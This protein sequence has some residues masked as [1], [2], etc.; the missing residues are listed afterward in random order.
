MCFMYAYYMH[1]RTRVSPGCTLKLPVLLGSSTD[2]DLARNPLASVT[3]T[4]VVTGVLMKDIQVLQR[5]AAAVHCATDSA[6]SQHVCAGTHDIMPPHEENSC[7]GQ[8]D[9]PKK[10][11]LISVV[12][13]LGQPA[14]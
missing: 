10:L 5:L 11:E 3:V 6:R 12:E 9:G 1:K 7:P 14:T 8:S 4:P 13:H 2:D